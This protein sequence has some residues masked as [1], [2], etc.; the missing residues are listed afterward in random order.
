[1]KKLTYILSAALCGLALLPSC[2]KT[3]VVET[4]TFVLCTDGQVDN[5]I[6]YGEVKNHTE[7]VEYFEYAS[8][9]VAADSI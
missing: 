9:A 6:V 3:D 4:P 8:K 1:M 5:L 7:E 2:R